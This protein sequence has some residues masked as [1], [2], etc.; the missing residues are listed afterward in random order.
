VEQL[1]LRENLET[2]VRRVGGWCETA[3]SSGVS[4]VEQLGS[5]SEIGD[6]QRGR[7]V[8]EVE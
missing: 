1:L 4:G 2:V 5:C 7:E 6:S 8:V 3:A